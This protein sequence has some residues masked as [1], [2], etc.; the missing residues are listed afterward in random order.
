MK[1]IRENLSAD[2]LITGG[3][4]VQSVGTKRLRTVEVLEDVTFHLHKWHSNDST[5]EN[6][7]R[8]SKAEEDLTYAK[9]HLGSNECEEKL[10]GLPWN[11]TE[12]I[13]TIPTS[14]ER[15]IPTKREALSELAKVYD[16][17]GLASPS[18]LVAKILY[19]EV[20]EAK[21]HWDSKLDDCFKR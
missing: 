19:R 6:Y 5:L 11:K 9:Q 10:L 16:P 17:L 15:E 3:E 2:D 7:D 21:L 20:C 4:S 14:Y 1:E 18:T 8:I 13:L 12:D